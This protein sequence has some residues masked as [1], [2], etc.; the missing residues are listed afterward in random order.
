MNS[1]DE[2]EDSSDMREKELLVRAEAV[3][4]RERHVRLQLQDCESAVRR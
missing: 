3:K 4:K 1:L 2:K